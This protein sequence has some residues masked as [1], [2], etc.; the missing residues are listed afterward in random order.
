MT[1]VRHVVIETTDVLDQ[2]KMM[3]ALAAEPE[4]MMFTDG[5]TLMSLLS[6]EDAAIVASALE[7]RGIPAASV[8]RMKPWMLSGMVALPACEMARKAGGAPVLDVKLAKQAKAGGKA[9]E[10][11][12][13]IADQLRAMASLPM[14]FHMKGLVETLKLGDRMDDVVETMIVLYEQEDT[15]MFWPLFRAVLPEGSGD[16]VGYAM[17]EEALITGRNRTMVDR[18]EPMLR[19]GNAFIAVGALHLPGPGRTDRASSEQ[20]ATTCRASADPPITK[21]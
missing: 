8:A 9:V 5:T 18:A 11:L 19:R 7:E 12:E 6:P 16:E 17:F 4:L 1:V 14:E 15:G 21:P 3:A 13:T 10:G 2:A 20:P